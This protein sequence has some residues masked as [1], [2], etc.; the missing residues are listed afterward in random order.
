LEIK[1]VSEGFDDAIGCGDKE[2]IKKQKGCYLSLAGLYVDNTGQSSEEMVSSHS[3]SW[4]S[5]EF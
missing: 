2:K 4:P 5:M 3:M 1:S